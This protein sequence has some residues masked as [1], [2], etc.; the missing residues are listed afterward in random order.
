MK[1]L[2]DFQD[3]K[4]ASNR[5]NELKAELGDNERERQRLQEAVSSPGNHA[6]SSIEDAAAALIAGDAPPGQDA[7]RGQMQAQLEA[8]TQK[9]AVL[10]AAVNLQT[11]RLD[12]LRSKFSGEIA[13]EAEPEQRKLIKV[14]IKAAA[15]LSKAYSELCQFRESLEA[16]GFILGYLPTVPSHI[17][18]MGRWDVPTSR[19]HQL[20]DE[21]TRDGFVNGEYK[22]R[23]MPKHFYDDIPE[24]RFV[25][26]ISAGPDGIAVV[27]VRR[28]GKVDVVKQLSKPE[29]AREPARTEWNK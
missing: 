1:K 11:A 10:R 3:Y 29:P 12:K 26:S 22:N 5:L 20:L 16:D 24:G 6:G 28:G 2:M 4:A 19:V 23:P 14:A 21:A 18:Q 17:N 7:S 8:V 15:D 13:K 25:E 9:V 27:N